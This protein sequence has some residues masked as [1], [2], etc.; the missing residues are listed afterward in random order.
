MAAEERP[1]GG[2]A[3]AATDDSAHR[4]GHRRGLGAGSR[5]GGA[6]AAALA[7][8][9][10]AILRGHLELAAENGGLAPWCG[11]PAVA[12]ATGRPY[13][14][15]CD[16][17]RRA[18]PAWYPQAGPIVT[19]Y[20][21]DLLA[22]LR[23]AGVPHDPLSLPDPRPTLLGLVRAASLDEGWYLLRVTDHFLLLR[24][25]GFGL[26]TLHDNRHT[27]EVVTARTRGRRKLS[28]AARLLGGPL[29]GAG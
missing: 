9:L 11:P 24:S 2:N 3:G 23:D 27:G 5:G 25:H 10:P 17:L 20:W 22:V 6:A 7:Q 18:A 4:A 21:R 13:A 29:L 28:H 8:G 15:A 26:A 14:E 19:A 1:T 12:L 16:M